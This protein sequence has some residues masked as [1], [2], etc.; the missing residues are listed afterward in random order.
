MVN[1]TIITGIRI[2][3]ELVFWIAVIPAILLISPQEAAH[4]SLC[5]LS[6]VGWDWCPGCGLGR[7]MKLITMGHFKE[8]MILH[9]LSGFAWLV[10]IHRIYSLLKNFKTNYT[11]G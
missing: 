4:F 5:P 1:N 11:Y 8:A 10:I 6:A 7:G 9:P 3:W 2:P